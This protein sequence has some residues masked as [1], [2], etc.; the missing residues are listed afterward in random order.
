MADRVLGEASR[1][2]LFGE[3]LEETGGKRSKHVTK[4]ARY[5]NEKAAE[6]A[7]QM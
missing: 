4:K 5:C 3:E 7:A 2:R 6:D 1:L